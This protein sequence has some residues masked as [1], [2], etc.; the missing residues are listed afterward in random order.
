M[1]QLERRRECG[2]ELLGD[3]QHAAQLG[4]ARHPI[5]RDVPFP[6][7]DLRKPLDL[8]E[9]GEGTADGVGGWGVVLFERG[10]GGGRRA[11]PPGR[12]GAGGAGGGGFSAAG[13]APAA[14]G[15]W[16][17][18]AVVCERSGFLRRGANPGSVTSDYSD[19]SKTPPCPSE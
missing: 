2:I 6:T 15:S 9:V 4:R 3:T 18:W 12:L 17:A 13:G 8:R 5:G 7:A 16:A 14:R 1:T 11:R 10:G 19:D